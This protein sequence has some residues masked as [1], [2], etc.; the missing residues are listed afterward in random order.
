MSIEVLIDTGGRPG[1]AE[2]LEAAVSLVLRR[3]GADEGEVSLAILDDDAIQA[4][5]RQHLGHDYPTDVLSFALWEEG[6]PVLG[7]VYVGYEQALRQATDE[8]VAPREE[9][10]RLAIHGTLHVLGYDHPAAAEARAASEMYLVQE[11]LLAELI[12]SLGV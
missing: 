6:E 12:G 2:A 8:G 1:L 10:M 11:E 9:L 3:H 7:D 5:N 4:L